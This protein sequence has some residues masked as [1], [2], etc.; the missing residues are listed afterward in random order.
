M[1]AAAT[2]QAEPKELRVSYRLDSAPIQFRNERGEADGIIIDF[3]KLWSQKSGVPVSFIGAYNREAQQLV[4]DGDADINAGL[5]ENRKRAAVFDFSATI[6]SSP[7]YLYVNPNLD[8]GLRIQD[9][10]QLKSFRVAVTRGSFHENYMR[11]HY[12]GIRLI[13]YDGYESLFSVAGEDKYDAFIA[14]PM[15]LAYHSQRY[16]H[17]EGFIQTEPALY[18]HGYKAAVSKQRNQLLQLINRYMARISSD[19]KA[20]IAGKW[21]GISWN[22]AGT[23]SPSQLTL[24]QQEKQWLAQHRQIRIGIDPDWPPIEFLD[25]RQQY[26]GIASDYVHLLERKLGVSMNYDAE[27]NWKQVVEQLKNGNIDVLPAVS[28]TPEREKYL[29]FTRPY[30]RFPYVIFTRTDAELVTGIEE[31][32]GKTV[33]VE[34][35]YANH[36]LLRENHPSLNLMLVDTTEQALRA[37]SLG[38]ADAY[39]GNLAAASHILLETGIANLKVAAP[40]PY[41]NDLAFGV[42]KDMPELLNILQKA[43]DTVSVKQANEFKRRWFSVRFEHNADYALLMKVVAGGVSIIALAALWLLMISR[44]KEALRIKEERFRLVMSAA[45]EGLWDWN[46]ETGQVYFNPGIYN[47][48]GYEPGDIEKN[49]TGLVKLLPEDRRQQTVEH[50][51]KLISHCETP[52][53]YEFQIRRNDG[54]AI[55]VLARGT[56]EID[57]YGKPVRSL[58]SL[59]DVTEK[60]AALMRL[61]QSEQ[62]LKTI[63]DAIPLAIIICEDDGT[64]VYANRETEKEASAGQSAVGLN[65]M[66]F[67]DDPEDREK[68]YREYTRNGRVDA[69]PMRYRTPSGKLI[70]GII[71]LL[72]VYFDDGVKNLGVLVDLTDRIRMERELIA[73]K[74]QAESANQIKSSFLA[75]M[76]HEIRTPM[77]AIIGLGHLLMKTDL[78]PRQIDYI[79]KINTSAHSLLGIINDVLD[80]SKIEAGKLE[81]EKTEFALDDIMANLS[82][83]IAMRAEEKGLEIAY[84]IDP[85]IPMR[86]LGDPLRLGQVLINLTQNA[87]KFTDKGAIQVNVQLLEFSARQVRLGFSVTD[88][89]IGIDDQQLHHLFNAFSQADESHTRR[90]GGTGLG[91][92]ICKQ[93]VDLMGGSINVKSQLGKGSTFSFQ[94]PFDI[95]NRAATSRHPIANF[96]GKRALV[97]DDNSTARQILGTMLRSLSFDV[98]QAASGAEALEKLARAGDTQQPGYDL[99][100]VDWKMPGMNGTQTVQH[101]RQQIPDRQRP[102]IIM[103]TSYGR[104]EVMHQADLAGLDGFLI[105]PI[106][107]S[108]LYNCIVENMLGAGQS[109]PESVQSSNGG[110]LSGRILLVE[111]NA[112]NQQVAQG[113]LEH[114]GLRVTV[115]G[116]GLEAMEILKRGA[117]DLVLADI[118]MPRMDGYELARAIREQERQTHLPIVAMTAHAMEGDREKCLQAGMDDHLPKPIDPDQLYATLDRW[119][120]RSDSGDTRMLADFEFPDYV[121]GVNLEQ[122]LRRIGGN[123]QLLMKLLREFVADYQQAEQTIDEAIDALDFPLASRW[124][125]TI[126]GIAG[127]IGAGRLQ[128]MAEQLSQSLKTEDAAAIA[129]IQ[130]DFAGAFREVMQSIRQCIDQCDSDLRPRKG[131]Q[132]KTLDAAYLEEV[133]ALVKQGNPE[134]GTLLERINLDLVDADMAALINQALDDVHNYDFANAESVLS[135]IQAQVN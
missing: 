35:S 117:F 91:L 100:L 116:D 69:M 34:Q 99:L 53:E 43:L 67:Y 85:A 7:Y 3:W 105:K 94:L 29:E 46:M 132:D 107:S 15:Y 63:I 102:V 126:Q 31:L 30:L 23:E 71:S 123:R 57:R 16:P 130:G 37:V 88:T 129:A 80:F 38:Q 62:Q 8:R 11:K 134:A 103:V 68:L 44:Q 89:G 87:I 127:N 41:S 81:I 128:E 133:G 95:A 70:E 78:N 13:L 74:T 42:R 20:A 66:S 106:N 45:Q 6:L 14:Q 125:H 115:A 73:A 9:A 52:F 86:L 82:S 22:I 18:T 4:I 79:E 118:Q 32:I 24:S 19:E 65:M 59:S 111:D 110:R 40:T 64:I 58:G 47:I 124:L 5:F 2:A 108:I 60:R 55:C 26:S 50:F 98:D 1:I 72:P 101:I 39:V 84:A 135:R 28:R 104:E 76:S 17:A 75:N 121:D 122:G 131:D 12:P 93:L 54:Q 56:L 92:A 61:A 112:I 120:N 36:D 48:L 119:L 114:F 33:V 83:M 27:L 109:Q 77:N 21:L 90:Y 51:R 96:K 10:A 49:F 113:I 25:A 97:V